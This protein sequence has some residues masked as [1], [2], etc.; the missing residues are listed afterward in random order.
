LFA[1]QLRSQWPAL[2]EVVFLPDPVGMAQA[3]S[4]ITEPLRIK[5]RFLEMSVCDRSSRFDPSS[6]IMHA[7]GVACVIVIGGDGT[8]RVVAKGSQEMPLIPLSTGT[9]N[10]FPRFLESTL[11][12]LAAGYYPPTTL[13]RFHHSD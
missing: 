2:M 13:C 5:P 4:G 7:Q 12:G 8:S 6:G 10:A 1:G 11:A 9:N 3:L